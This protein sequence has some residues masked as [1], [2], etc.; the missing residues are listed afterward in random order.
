MNGVEE[1]EKWAN[2]WFI[3]LALLVF[4]SGVI[5]SIVDVR[6]VRHGVNSLTPVGIVGIVFLFVGLGLNIGSRII[7]GKNYSPRVRT[8]PNQ[9]LITKGPYHYIRHP[10]YLGLLLFS[11]S[12]PMIQ[13]SLI[14]FIIMLLLIPLI[15]RRIK[16][17][18]KVLIA[19]FGKDYEEYAQKTWKLIPYVY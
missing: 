4:G 18:E 14:G 17:E 1:E 16:I 10:V 12:V 13:D 9:K 3:P 6:L 15:I 8:T 19:K 5:V 2:L 11:L 7:L